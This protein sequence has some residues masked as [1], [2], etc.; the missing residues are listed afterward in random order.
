MYAMRST[1]T[2]L[3]G[4]VDEP[5][6]QTMLFVDGSAFTGVFVCVCVCRVRNDGTEVDGQSVVLC[7]SCL[8]SFLRSLGSKKRP[9]CPVCA[10]VYDG[11]DQIPLTSDTAVRGGRVDFKL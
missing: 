6:S 7:G 2:E 4:R 1:C 8:P 9:R 11:P 10:Y 5:N 3:R